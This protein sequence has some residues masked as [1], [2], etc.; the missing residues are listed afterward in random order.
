M[1][2]LKKLSHFQ[3]LDREEN[4]KKKTWEVLAVNQVFHH[5]ISKYV[6]F[7]HVFI[8]FCYFLIVISILEL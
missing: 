1:S 8:N 7:A 2:N 6:Y 4:F 5:L 3:N